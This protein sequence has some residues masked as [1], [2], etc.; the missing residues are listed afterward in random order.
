MQRFH[1]LCIITYLL[2]QLP[3]SLGRRGDLILTSA[4]SHIIGLFRVNAVLSITQR[5]FQRG[6]WWVNSKASKLLITS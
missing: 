1:A 5:A 2:S 6:Q 3:A 4:Q